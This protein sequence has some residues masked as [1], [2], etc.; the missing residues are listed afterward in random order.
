MSW[1]KYKEICNTTPKTRVKNT[2]MSHIF[3][4]IAIVAGAGILTGVT[5]YLIAFDPEKNVAIEIWKSIL[6]S[7]CACITVPLFLQIISNNLLVDPSVKADPPPYP[8]NYFILAGFC[9]LAGFYAKR[10]LEDLFTKISKVEQKVEAAK[11]K[12]DN[13]EEEKKELDLPPIALTARNALAIQEA[14]QDFRPEDI[15]MISKAI[16]HSSFSYRTIQGIARE[17]A[18]PEETVKLIL[19]SLQQQ[20]VAKSSVNKE[21]KEVWKIIVN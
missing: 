2:I 1:E 5:N 18:L 7:I 12:V 9:V 11:R 17:T 15:N 8:R 20:G 21:G 16:M 6:L 14:N 4:I 3:I 19:K 10:F 13:M